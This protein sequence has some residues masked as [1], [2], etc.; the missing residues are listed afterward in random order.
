MQISARFNC[1]SEMKE[2][3]HEKQTKTDTSPVRPRCAINDDGLARRRWHWSS[4]CIDDVWVAWPAV[5]A[6]FTP[7]ARRLAENNNNKI[8]VN[9]CWAYTAFFIFYFILFLFLALSSISISISRWMRAEIC[10]TLRH[11]QL[12]G[13]SVA[14]EMLDWITVIMRHSR[15]VVKGRMSNS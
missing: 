14:Y 2:K 15:W 1:S 7:W 13:G 5:R 9:N 10:D 12:S 3:L 6:I 8:R 11:Y 4:R